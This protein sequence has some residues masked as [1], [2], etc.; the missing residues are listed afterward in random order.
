MQDSN[1][2]GDSGSGSGSGG[3]ITCGDSVETTI[4]IHS[5]ILC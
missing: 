1:V 2:G 5:S 4:G 3:S